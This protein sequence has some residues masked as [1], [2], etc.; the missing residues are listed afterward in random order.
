MENIE[1]GRKHGIK[2]LFEDLQNY[3]D[4][5]IELI[6]LQ[7]IDKI[8]GGISSVISMVVIIIILTMFFILLNIGLAI[9]IGNCLGAYYYGFLILSGFYGIVGLLFYL[10]R[11]K[12][13]KHP[14]R[15]MLIKKFLN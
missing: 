11:D 1:E 14:V 3:V 4:T 5:R 9:W 10:S 7:A 6:K 2:S 12:W 13:V 15:D 8:S